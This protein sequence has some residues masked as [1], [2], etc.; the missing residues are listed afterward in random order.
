MFIISILKIK[1][2]VDK[3]L[4]CQSL[5]SEAI[6]K[7]YRVMIDVRWRTGFIFVLS[8]SIQ[9]NGHEDLSTEFFMDGFTDEERVGCVECGYIPVLSNTTMALE[10]AA[11]SASKAW[12]F[13]I[14]AW[15]KKLSTKL[16]FIQ[17]F[18]H[19]IIIHSNNCSQSFHSFKHFFTE[20]SFTQT[21]VDK[22]FIH[23]NISL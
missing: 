23:S 10:W 21:F 7:F 5:K 18:L 20:L 19:E 16:S 6:L 13:W 11:T 22:I 14:F 8:T 4:K 2:E 12:C 3:L 9:Q 1:L 15:T 17:T